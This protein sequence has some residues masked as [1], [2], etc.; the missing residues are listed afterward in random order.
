MNAL[1]ESAIAAHGGLARWQALERVAARL[2]IGGALWDFKG[3]PGLFADV[4]FTAP[5]H[6][7]DGI[8]FDGLGGNGER[9]VF[10]PDRV[11]REAADGTLLEQRDAPRA[12]FGAG[13]WDRIHAAYFSSY[14]MSNYL[15]QPFLYT[16]P[17]VHVE[18]IAPWQEQGETWRRLRIVVPDSLASHSREQVACFGP[19]GLL[20]RHDYSV[21]V[22]GG[23][24]GANYASGYRDVNGIMVP[25]QR[26]VYGR[27]ENGERIAAPL[28]VSIDVAEIAFG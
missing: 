18:E 26:R 19:D 9:S 14:A 10:R 3:Q 4:G 25:L 1:L 23:A 15:A 7:Q 16:L 24:T 17:G 28:L 20:R 22:L 21:D 12:S 8:V 11:R 27:Q 6:G 13:D 2:H 5:L